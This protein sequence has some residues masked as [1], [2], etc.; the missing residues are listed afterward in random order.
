MPLCFFSPNLAYIIIIMPI[1][2]E[3][4]R[5]GENLNPKSNV[6]VSVVSEQ[7]P[8]CPL[9]HHDCAQAMPASGVS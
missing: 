7:R 2:P 3:A 5:F 6:S 1:N 8:N 9:L 4:E